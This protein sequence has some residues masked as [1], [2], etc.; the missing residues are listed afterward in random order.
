MTTLRIILMKKKEKKK[1]DQEKQRAATAMVILHTTDCDATIS[2][3]EDNDDMFYDNV[4][5]AYDR[6]ESDDS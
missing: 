6:S 2:I 4:A 3:G 5:L 1:D